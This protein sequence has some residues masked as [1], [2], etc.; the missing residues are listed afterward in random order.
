MTT[1][2]TSYTGGE[3]PDPL[4]TCG[5]SSRGA[6]Y[7][8]PLIALL[9][10]TP[11]ADLQAEVVGTDGSTMSTANGQLCVVDE[12]TY[13][14]TDPVYGNTGKQILQDDH[15]VLLIARRPYVAG[16]LSR[17]DRAA[18]SSRYRLVVH[19]RSLT[20]ANAH[21]SEANRQ[22]ANLSETH[23]LRANSAEHD[24]PGN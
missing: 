14:S 15:A 16:R 18:G 4:Q 17:D 22:L 23:T 2:L 10:S 24:R 6:S 9:P 11:S 21:R 8:L 12:S 1:K 20:G 13:R 5:W 7:G 3:S 19:R